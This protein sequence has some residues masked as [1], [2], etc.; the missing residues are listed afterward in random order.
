VID[1]VDDRVEAGLKVD[2]TR[3]D[4]APMRFEELPTFSHRG[5]ALSSEGAGVG[6]AEMPRPPS[7][8]TRT[9]AAARECYPALRQAQLQAQLQVSR[10]AQ[11][12]RGT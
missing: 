10:W 8:G 2:E 5:L 3:L 6:S 4:T 7:P 12:S 9:R 1:L 11:S